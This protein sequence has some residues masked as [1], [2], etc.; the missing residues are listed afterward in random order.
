MLRDYDFKTAWL[1]LLILPSL[2]VQKKDVP[3]CYHS[4]QQ[5]FQIKLP[6]HTF[7]T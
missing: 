6:S 1:Q 5:I 7:A 2:L 3:S 4:P